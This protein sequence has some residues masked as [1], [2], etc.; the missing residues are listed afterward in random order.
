MKA[1]GPLPR[2]NVKGSDVA[3]SSW[4]GFCV[5]SWKNQELLID[6]ARSVRDNEQVRDVPTGVESVVQVDG[7]SRSES[8]DEF[9]RVGVKSK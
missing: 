9:T 2:F 7:P 1:P 5:A 4:V 6:Y 3:W 8:L